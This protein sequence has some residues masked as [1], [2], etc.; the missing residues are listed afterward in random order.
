MENV[1]GVEQPR[2]IVAIAYVLAAI[3]IGVFLEKVVAL[4]LAYV[5]V[6]DFAVV[7]DYSL[8]TLVGFVIAAV[9]AVVVWRIPKTQSVSLEIALELR[10]VTWP[11]VRET[12]AATVAV[13]VASAIAAVIL[14]LFDMIWSWL[15]TKIY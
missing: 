13:I 11:S 7:G 1:G 2:R 12:R 14:G 8:S 15:S 4:V 3:A 9:A 6:N 5:R 10:R